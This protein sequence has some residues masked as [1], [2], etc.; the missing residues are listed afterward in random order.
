MEPTQTE[1][2]GSLRP[3]PL[4]I[5][6]RAH[7]GEISRE[8]NHRAD[9]PEASAQIRACYEPDSGAQASRTSNHESIGQTL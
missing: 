2:Q 7:G 4:C 6:P 1:M 9:S 3:S 5:E 8:E